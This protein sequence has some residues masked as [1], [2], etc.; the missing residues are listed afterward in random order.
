LQL[1]SVSFTLILHAGFMKTQLLIAFTLCCSIVSF[2]QRNPKTVEE[3]LKKQFQKIY[4]W[5][6]HQKVDDP[7]DTYDSMQ[8]ANDYILNQILKQGYNNRAFFNYPFSS[9]SEYV[10]VV[11]CKDKSFRIYSWDTYTGG[12]M[13]IFYAVAQY[14][15]KDN[16]V[17]TES[18]ADTSGNDPGLWYSKIYAFSDKGR[19]YYFCIGHGIY[20]TA[21]LGLDVT[22]YTVKGNLLVQAPIIK[23]QKGLTNS[24][25]VSYDLS[26]LDGKTDHSIVFD[27]V[28]KELKIPVVDTKGK[29]SARNII[30]KF[31]GEYFERDG[32]K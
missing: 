13:H 19:K 12:T 3:E 22:I 17:Y 20:S 6:E 30:Y 25:H 18:L 2:S 5:E 28:T 11:S 1:R 15:G 27:E 8:R 4:Y 14:L 10:D 31:N 32:I 21:D 24:I 7:I 23:T 16:K 9:L 26:S 29:M